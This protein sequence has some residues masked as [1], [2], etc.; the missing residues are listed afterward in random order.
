[1][2]CMW[3]NTI[4][5]GC[6][7]LLGVSV[8][9]CSGDEAANSSGTSSG[10]VTAA[11]G[12]GSSATGGTSSSSTTNAVSCNTTVPC[13]GTIDGTWQV[14]AT[15]VLGDLATADLNSSG[16]PAACAQ[17][18]QSETVATA[19]TVRFENGVQT[20]SLTLTTNTN[21]RYTTACASAMTGT[22]VTL[23]NASCAAYGQTLASGTDVSNA[24]CSLTDGACDC[25]VTYVRPSSTPLSYTISGSNITYAGSTS[26]ASYCVEGSTL[27]F[28]SSNPRM[29][30]V[31]LVWTFHKV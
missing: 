9:Q 17:Y 31:T 4:R 27:T 28:S 12:G 7:V 21:I 30:D 22:S 8:S 15:C 1:M 6:L 14:D 10:G 18:I 2:P 23:D 19:G 24:N 26:P 3:K 20:N 29:P 11:S 16:L 25:S 13:G 5:L